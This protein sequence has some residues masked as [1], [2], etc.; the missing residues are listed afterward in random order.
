[1]DEMNDTTL[2]H[3]R[4]STYDPCATLRIKYHACPPTRSD[5]FQNASHIVSH[6]RQQ[7]QCAESCIHDPWKDPPFTADADATGRAVLDD[8]RFATRV[9][10]FW[11]ITRTVLIVGL[12]PRATIAASRDTKLFETNFSSPST[13]IPQI[14]IVSDF[15]K[16]HTGLNRINTTSSC[17]G[18][19]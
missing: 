10:K 11:S 15:M 17:T 1:M 19:N 2:L 13:A 14:R 18:S 9:E 12:R 3:K 8:T 6:V 7:I 5:M 4:G 16:K